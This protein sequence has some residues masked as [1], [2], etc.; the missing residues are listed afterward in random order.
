M[1]S[2]LELQILSGRQSPMAAQALTLQLPAPQCWGEFTFYLLGCWPSP[3]LTVGEVNRTPCVLGHSSNFVNYP[4]GVFFMPWFCLPRCIFAF[5]KL[6][7]TSP[8][9]FY[10]ASTLFFESPKPFSATPDLFP[11]SH[12]PFPP[13]PDLF[14][15]HPQLRLMTRRAISFG[16]GFRVDGLTKMIISISVSI[17]SPC[18]LFLLGTPACCP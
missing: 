8:K 5:S 3:C 2:H 16:L 9:S 6:F 14:S 7:F 17:T 18:F 1:G 11:A 10:A 4:Q 13:D 12:H 15:S